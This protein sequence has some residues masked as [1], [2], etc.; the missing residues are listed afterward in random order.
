MQ[1]QQLTELWQVQYQHRHR[2]MAI[3]LAV[4]YNKIHCC[5]LVL[6]I[7]LTLITINYRL[8][9]MKTRCMWLSTMDGE[10]IVLIKVYSD[11]HC[12]VIH[13]GT[14]CVVLKMF[15]NVSWLRFSVHRN[16]DSYSLRAYHPMSN[17][18]PYPD[19]I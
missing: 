9:L 18:P 3:F 11:M 7:S 17:F 1:L 2:N 15:K 4:A 12:E 5:Q 19:S 16:V 10:W 13:S 14:S 6:V 8:V